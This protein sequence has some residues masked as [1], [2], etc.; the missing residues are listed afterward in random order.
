LF[1]ELRL[2]EKRDTR[3]GKRNEEELMS[4]TKGK[5]AKGWTDEEKAAMKERAAEL[6]AEAKANKDRAAGES[7]VLAKIAEM[8][9]ADRDMAKRIH[10]LV[11]AN[12]P[13]LSPKTWY[14]QPAYAKDGEVVCF[15]QS[16]E[17]FNTR[18]ATF[19]FNEAA[20]LDEGTMWATA[21]AIKEL[22]PADEAKLGALIKKAAS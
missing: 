15:F 14:G 3:V 1:G 13:N 6:K 4:A 2:D 5:S 10:E 9:G 19:G 7:A 12:A 16:K 22:S 8:K 11:K 21:F 20:N 17:K 18:Y